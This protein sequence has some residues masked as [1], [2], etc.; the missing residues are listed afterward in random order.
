MED[1]E[2]LGLRCLG[3]N[4]AWLVSSWKSLGNE[5]EESMNTNKVLKTLFC[6]VGNELWV[7]RDEALQ[8][9]PPL[10][11]SETD[12]IRALSDILCDVPDTTWSNAQLSLKS[13]GRNKEV[14]ISHA[15]ILLWTH[16]R[17]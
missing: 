7:A 9:A 2:T 4:G 17:V 3:E 10:G 13:V 14:L 16:G 6:A 12:F 5:E 15:L 8:Q 11:L 1:K